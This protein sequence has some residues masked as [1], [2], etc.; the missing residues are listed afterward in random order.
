MLAG[1]GNVESSASGSSQSSASISTGDKPRIGVTVSNLNPN[2]YAVAYILI[3]TG[4]YVQDVESALRLRRPACRW[5]DIVV[6]VDGTRV[7]SMEEMTSILQSKQAGD[8]ATLK[9]TAWR[10]AWTA[11]RTR[12]PSPTVSTST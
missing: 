6:E 4:A 11:T 2:S 12:P 7:S 10:V 9:S 5:A 8:T 1:N 3:P